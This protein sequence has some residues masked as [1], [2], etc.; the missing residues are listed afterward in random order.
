MGKK[1]KHGLGDAS[2]GHPRKHQNDPAYIFT[3]CIHLHRDDGPVMIIFI[4][5]IDARLQSTWILTSS[6]GDTP[7]RR[8]H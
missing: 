5:L 6:R 2:C 3:I 7:I 1:K 8:R 4:V